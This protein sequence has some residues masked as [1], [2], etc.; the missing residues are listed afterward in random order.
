VPARTVVNWSR[1]NEDITW[2]TLWSRAGSTAG[3]PTP[4][5]MWPAEI[6]VTRRAEL[7]RRESSSVLRMPEDSAAAKTVPHAATRR[8][9]ATA[10]MRARRRR[11]GNS[12]L[13]RCSDP[14]ADLGQSVDVG[15][16]EGRVEFAAELGDVLFEKV[17]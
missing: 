5:R 17:G 10:T 15:R 2:T 3:E 7:R 11:I 6:S 4:R 12:C 9:V 13:A 16:I 1:P 14:V 8:L